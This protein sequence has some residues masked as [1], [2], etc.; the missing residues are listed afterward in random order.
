MKPHVYNRPLSQTWSV[1]GPGVPKDWYRFW[2]YSLFSLLTWNKNV[3]DVL[4]KLAIDTSL[5]GVRN[6]KEDQEAKKK[7]LKKLENMKQD[8][9]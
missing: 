1:E 9:A 3:E 5:G 6:T 8:L 2:V 4:I 7:D